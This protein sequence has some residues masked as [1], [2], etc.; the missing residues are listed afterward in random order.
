MNPNEQA[1]EALKRWQKA[2]SLT[3]SDTQLGP[4]NP[5][6]GNQPPADLKDVEF[7]KKRYQEAMERGYP[8]SDRDRRE[9]ES[10]QQVLH[11]RDEDVWAIEQQL[12]HKDEDTRANEQQL[13]DTVLQSDKTRVEPSRVVLDA[14]DP[15]LNFPAATPPTPLDADS[16]ARNAEAANIESQNAATPQNAFNLE[17]PQ[18]PNEQAILKRKQELMRQQEAGTSGAAPVGEMGQ[19]GAEN[20]AHTSF[21]ANLNQDQANPSESGP[22]PEPLS[23]EQSSREAGGTA[24]D[25]ASEPIQPPPGRQVAGKVKVDR[26]PWLVSMILLGCTLGIL[27][28]AWLAAR[29][30]LTPP[31]KDPVA[32]GQ[33]F[34]AGTQQAR[35][36]QNSKAI[37]DL[38]QAIRLSPSDPNLYLN[39][40]VAHYQAG[41][42]SA[43][44]NDY[45]QALKLNP[46]FAEAW[47]NRSQVYVTQQRYDEA[48]SDASRA[49][50]LNPN[51]TEAY[52]NRG[53]A[54]FGRNNLDG[55]FQ[56]YQ[57]VLQLKQDPANWSKAYNNLGNIN[58]ARNQLDPA[59]KNYDQAI[60]Q[61][62]SY[63][64][65]FFNRA[66]ALERKGQCPEA[67]QG[68]RDA[69]NLY[70]NQG[71][72]EMSKRAQSNVDRLGQCTTSPGKS[73]QPSP[74]SSV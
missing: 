2:L 63:A 19:Q 51:L 1:Y 69:L 54:L 61:V 49:I 31:A 44:L 47:S 30:Y 71:N 17:Q 73:P 52:L 8:L 53:N 70:Q 42:L 9:L 68:F 15:R 65:A 10:L 41:N 18:T 33:F 4:P 74:T 3:D 5:G 55:A 12:A 26:R 29:T 67:V 46:N 13:A 16:E 7:Y 57:K 36:G 64:D 6:Q 27:A 40:G 22:A 58:A 62:R 50:Q 32:A 21:E 56:D 72:S 48:N 24:P 20:A 14:S 37:A 23:S 11:L 35:Q 38:D 25:P 45:N 34:Q 39:R 28:G 43:A 60:E 66:L 59:I